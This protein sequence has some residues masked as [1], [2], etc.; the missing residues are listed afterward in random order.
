MLEIYNKKFNEIISTTKGNR[1][2]MLLASLMTQMEQF[3]KI[4]MVKEIFEY[5]TDSAVRELYLAI[6]NARRF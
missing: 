1:R 3:Y 4:S 2:T 5:E 6:S